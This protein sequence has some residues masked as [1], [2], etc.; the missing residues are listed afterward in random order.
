MSYICRLFDNTW[1]GS[2]YGSPPSDT[3][4][5]HIGSSLRTIILG[6]TDLADVRFDSFVTREHSDMTPED[7]STRIG[8]PE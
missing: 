3:P 2:T 8:R 4:A 5:E 1:H 7:S 6:H